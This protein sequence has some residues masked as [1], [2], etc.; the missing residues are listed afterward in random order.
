MPRKHAY[1]S[2]QGNPD[3]LLELIA[4]TAMPTGRIFRRTRDNED[5]SFKE[6]IVLKDPATNVSTTYIFSHIE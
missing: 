3:E 4:G 6:T 1:R 2:R 5:L